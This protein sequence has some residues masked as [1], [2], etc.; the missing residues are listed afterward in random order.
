MATTQ[1]PNLTSA[2]ALNGTEPFIAVQAG[3]SVRVSAA[4]IGAYVAANFGIPGSGTVT[5]VSVVTANGV[6]ASVATPTTT[7]AI[8]LTVSPATAGNNIGYLNLPQNSQSA[9][10]TLVLA[11][12]GKSIY[13][14]SADT[15]AR[16]WTIPANGSVAY[17]IGTALTFIN[18]TTAGVITI[19]IT[20]DTMILAG[21]GTTG[22]RALAASS[23]ATAVKMTATRW[24]I[25]GAGLT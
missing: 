9:D 7:P 4:Q 22:S 12:S 15:S 20:S 11:D 21:V 23:M 13:H 5:S 16:T 18:D 19:A 6:S 10:Y 1:I 17:P 3:V 24:I 14:P 2:I 25:N 8:T